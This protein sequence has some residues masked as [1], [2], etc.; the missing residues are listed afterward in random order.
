MQ[1]KIGGKGKVHHIHP[2]I[3]LAGDNFDFTP[4]IVRRVI[5]EAE[6][7]TIDWLKQHND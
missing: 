3:D 2:I 5:D 1:V 6:S 7:K 4:E